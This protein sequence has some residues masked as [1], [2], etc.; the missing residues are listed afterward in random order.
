MITGIRAMNTRRAAIGDEALLRTLRLE[1]LR[2]EPHA[3]GSTYE[4][5]LART[6][7]DWRRWMSPGMAADAQGWSTEGADKWA[8]R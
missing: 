2:L 3:F 1:A 7:D 8:T 6:V 4:R 5:E